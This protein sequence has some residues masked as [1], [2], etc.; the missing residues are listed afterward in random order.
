[1][2]DA[3]GQ[4]YSLLEKGVIVCVGHNEEGKEIYTTAENAILLG[5][6]IIPSEEKRQRRNEQ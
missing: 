1:M 3:F 5:L 4:S 2:I 6:K